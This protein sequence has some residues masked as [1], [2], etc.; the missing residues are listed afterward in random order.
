MGHFKEFME[1]S[2]NDAKT[3]IYSLPKSHR[4]L[5]RG[6]SLNFHHNSTLKGDDGHI[7]KVEN[8]PGKKKITLASPWYYSR[9]FALTHEIAHLVYAKYVK[10]TKLETDWNKLCSKTKG[11]VRQNYEEIFCHTYANTYVHNKF[12]KHTHSQLEKFILDLPK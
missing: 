11:K 8:M 4:N 10:G 2:K 9:E 5:V 6:F 12:V 7:G 3:S 1:S